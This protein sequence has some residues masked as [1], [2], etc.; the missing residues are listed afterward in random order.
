VG[1]RI[2]LRAKAKARTRVLSSLYGS[3]AG[4]VLAVFTSKPQDT[5]EVMGEDDAIMVGLEAAADL[6]GAMER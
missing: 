1:H 4:T 2:G 6:S 3:R 5:F